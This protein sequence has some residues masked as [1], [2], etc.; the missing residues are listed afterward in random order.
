[1]KFPLAVF[2]RQ[3]LIQ[4]SN[5]GGKTLSG[6]SQFLFRVLWHTSHVEAAVFVCLGLKLRMLAKIFHADRTDQTWTDRRSGVKLSAVCRWDL[7]KN[8]ERANFSLTLEY[9]TWGSDLFYLLFWV[10]D[11]KLY[12]GKNEHLR[13]E[14][15]LLIN[16]SDALKLFD[17]KVEIA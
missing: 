1:M 11:E 15:A 16:L 14:F 7:A 2:F 8:K 6:K 4:A 5:P 13:F 17:L 12:P 10:R 3:V 9:W